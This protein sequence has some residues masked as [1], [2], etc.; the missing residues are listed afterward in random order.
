MAIYIDEQKKLFTLST[1][2]TSYQ[3]MA[4]KYLVLNHLY[5]GENI[6]Q[7]DMSYLLDY[8][9][10][11]FSGNPYE[12]GNERDY[13]LDSRPQE[14]S[15]NGVGDYRINS[16]SVI[17]ADGSDAADWRY[18]G[19]TIEKGKYAIPGMPAL[20]GEEKDADTLIVELADK[21]TRL[22][23]F[24][25]YSVWEERDIITR[26]VKFVNQGTDAIVLTK[27]ASMNLDLMS[28][29]WELMHFHGRHNLERQMERVPL[30]RGKMTVESVRGAS[31]I[32]R[33]SSVFQ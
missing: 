3:M 4:D 24:L 29:D 31:T 2:N 7:E 5:Y 13:S 28:G 8:Q 1:N 9:D 25:Y 17:N 23:A 12:A 32:F 33:L 27:A 14:Y 18:A 6:G 26:C 16:V 21:V 30:M 15:T 11:G 22:H 20:Y 19:Y 10:R